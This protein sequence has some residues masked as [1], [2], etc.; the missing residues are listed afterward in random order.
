MFLFRLAWSLINRAVGVAREEE[1][2]IRDPDLIVKY[3]KFTVR[4][5]AAFAAIPFALMIFFA[6]MNVVQP[7]SGASIGHVVLFGVIG[8]GVSPLI[9]YLSRWRIEVRGTLI[10]VV[11]MIGRPRT[12]SVL[13]ISRVTRR[14][15]AIPVSGAVRAYDSSGK[16]LFTVDPLAVGYKPMSDWLSKYHL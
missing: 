4:L 1:Q 9:L 6:I 15:G 13:D 14:S 10:T 5:F 7:A 11:P 16:R 3:P 2:G 12:F 8:V